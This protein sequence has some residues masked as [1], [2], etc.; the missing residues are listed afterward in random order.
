MSAF[1]PF[2]RWFPYGGQLFRADLIAG[3]A[4]AMV[5]IPQSMA[6]AQLA[7]LPAFYGLYAAFLPVVV[8]A[9]W[10]SSNHLAGGPVAVVSLMTA[11]MLST[12][13][14][15]GTET[16]IALAIMLAL[17]VGIMQLSLGL[18]KLG[19]IVN[20]LSHPVILGFTNAAA[21]IIGMSQ[22]GMLTG[23][24]MPK[25]DHF[26]TDFLRLLHQWSDTHLPTLAMGLLA[27]G[28]MWSTKHLAP[29]VPGVLIAVVVTTVLSWA[30][31]FEND[32]P[33]NLTQVKD[34]HLKRA[35]E[36]VD[37]VAARLAELGKQQTILNQQIKTL[38]QNQDNKSI[39]VVRAKAELTV[40]LAQ[41]KAQTLQSQQLRSSLRKV[42]VVREIDSDDTT[43]A[44]YTRAS[45]PANARLAAE[46]YQVRGVASGAFRLQGG[47]EVV[48]KIPDGLPE[49]KA[50][51]I[52]WGE[53]MSLLSAAV[54]I[55]LVGFME[56]ISI[57]KVI[58]LKT[59]Q[60]LDT[61]Q[62]LIGQGLA[63]IVGSFSQSYPTSGSFSRT[64]VNFNAG[65]KTG[66][67]QVITAVTVFVVLLFLTPLLYHL[68]QAVF[69]AIIMMAVVGLIN[70]AAV[71]HAW[72]ANRPDGIASVV[73]FAAT[74]TFAPNLDRGILVG[75]V[76]SLGFYLYR[77]MK[78]RVAQLGR[79]PDGALRD[80]GVYPELPTSSNVITLRF[81]DSLYFVNVAFFEDAVLAAV[82]DKP[83][84]KYLLVVGGGINQMDAS[85]EEVVRHLVE[86]LRASGVTLVFSGLKKQVL[87]VMRRTGLFELIGTA[88]IFPNED[89]ALAAIYH[90]LGP[91]GQGELLMTTNPPASQEPP[92]SGHTTP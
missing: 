87:D 44:L 31:G 10:G 43:V 78:P 81:D 47:G 56:A 91:E 5:L 90:W 27:M 57:A 69:G 79:H 48:G 85:G 21:L 39:S 22:I 72:Q 64:A 6:Y 62:E 17:V 32:M 80:I 49:I 71:K 18:L 20:F 13:A 28:L 67:S 9:L 53:F 7:G 46:T 34:P 58:A 52:S 25:T 83:Q 73:A 30:I 40:L 51:A 24:A 26:L 77:T 88:N 38:G 60:R 68:P 2:L 70:V 82:A 16:F 14:Q 41:I 86:R 35:I 75:V 76:L 66:M 74:L 92:I 63:N 8:A 36:E 42:A 19:V 33:G 37:H 65:A 23:L 45:A 15:P 84:A 89:Q 4:V 50:P 54:I 61:N 11:S 59:R 29:K 55:A 3:L 1:F 12:M